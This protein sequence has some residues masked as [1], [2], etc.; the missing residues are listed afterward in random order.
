MGEIVYRALNSLVV[1]Y[2]LLFVFLPVGLIF[3]GYLIYIVVMTIKEF[4]KK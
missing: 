1:Q 4:R 2:L 3:L